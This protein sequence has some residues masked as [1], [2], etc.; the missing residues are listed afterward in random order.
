MRRGQ[1]SEERPPMLAQELGW[2]NK[3][4]GCLVV[5]R[6][7]GGLNSKLGQIGHKLDVITHAPSWWT[8]AH[9]EREPHAVCR[10]GDVGVSSM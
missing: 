7:R 1:S 5:G 3:M 6:E 8:V 9:E 10:A 2:R 4:L